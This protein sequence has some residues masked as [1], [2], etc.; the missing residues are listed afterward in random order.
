M[1]TFALERLE[2]L[3]DVTRMTVGGVDDEDVDARPPASA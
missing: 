2:S 1:D 3:D